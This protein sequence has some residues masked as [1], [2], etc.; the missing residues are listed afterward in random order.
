MLRPVALA[1]CLVAACGG[2]PAAPDA[3][4][5]ARAPVDA[6]VDAQVD[7]QVDAATCPRTLLT[8][9]AAPAD[10]GWTVVSGGDATVTVGADAIGLTTRTVSTTGG[11]LLLT[12]PTG[13]PAGAPLAL[14]VVARIER[15]DRHNP[16]DAAVAILGAFTPPFGTPSQR[17]QMLYLDADAVGWA[18]DSARAPVALADGA[19]HT[20]VLRVDAAG[21]AT[22][23]VDGAAALTR[24]GYG[25]GTTLAIGDQ[26]N[27]PGVEAA[28]QLRSVTALCP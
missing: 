21:N 28:L 5:D 24:A 13:D 27:D 17:G 20:F 14:S 23:T 11:Q 7:A 1:V 4:V 9:G 22:V 12:H 2:E 8:G 10:Q 15:V 18:D 26:T 25:T 6:T 16:S 19:F 3:A